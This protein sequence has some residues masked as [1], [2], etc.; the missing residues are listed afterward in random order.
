MQVPHWHARGDKHGVEHTGQPPL[1]AQLFLLPHILIYIHTHTHTHTHIYMHIYAVPFL[2]WC[3]EWL[4]LSIHSEK[5][6]EMYVL[7]PKPS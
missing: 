6:E 2:N 3:F 1:K 5:N 4:L 7:D